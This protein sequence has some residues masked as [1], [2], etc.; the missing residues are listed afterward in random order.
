MVS[1]AIL[2]G[3]QSKRMGRDK[4][5]LE[6]GGRPVIERVIGQVQ[7][8]TDDLFISTN[9]PEKYAHLGLP[10]VPDIYPDKAALGGLYSV[11][12]AARHA[13]VLVVAC[14]MPFLKV[15][16]LQYLID[17]A[18]QADV[19]VPLINP[20]QPETLHAVYSKNCLPAIERRVLADQLRLIGF[21][22]DVTVR[23]VE[24]EEIIEFDPEFHSFVNMNTP[25]DWHRVQAI[26]KAVQDS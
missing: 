22:A 8:L 3:G 12:Q 19:V 16:L 26:A 7:T 15:A 21:F 5:F 14:D 13:H 23:Y 4:A 9:S 17:L 20:L 1:I 11:I 25:E 24:R 18:P 6:V 10:L 2:A